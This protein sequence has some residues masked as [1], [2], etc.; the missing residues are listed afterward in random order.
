MG[1]YSCIFSQIWKDKKFRQ[2]DDSGQKLFIAMLSAPSSNMAGYYE[3]PM[4]YALHDLNGWSEEKFL[5]CVRDLERL[6]MVSYDPEAEVVFVRNFLK[7]NKLNGIKQIVGAFEQIKGVQPSCLLCELHDSWCKFVDAP[8]R[9]DANEKLATLDEKSKESIG[10]KKS[11]EALDRIIS[12]LES[13][14][15][16]LSERQEESKDT[17]KK[18]KDTPIDTLFPDEKPTKNTLSIPH[19]NPIDTQEQEPVQEQ[20]QVP[21]PTPP[22]PPTP[23]RGDEA[24]ADETSPEPPDDGAV[25]VAE[26]VEIWNSELCPLGFPKVSK[27]TPERRKHFKARLRDGVERRELAWWRDRIAAIAGSE[28]MRKSAAEKAQWL[29]FDWLLNE[30]NLVKVAEGKYGRVL[31]LPRGQP[32]GQSMDEYMRELQKDPFWGG[33]GGAET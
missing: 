5:K 8:Y 32:P 2:L 13:M 24:A 21:V 16:T 20:V 29:D 22:T 7:H 25:K 4:A 11:L 19:A 18:Q 26:V 15:N 6:G 14:K 27:I 3:W 1:R 28:F 30:T 17:S 23:P 10:C 33:S 9:K 12:E 31:N